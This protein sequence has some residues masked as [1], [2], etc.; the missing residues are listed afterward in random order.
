MHKLSQLQNRDVK[1]EKKT[2]QATKAIR[3][4]S[5]SKRGDLKICSFWSRGKKGAQRGKYDLSL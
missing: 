1:T 5:S 3:Y 4:K 2:E